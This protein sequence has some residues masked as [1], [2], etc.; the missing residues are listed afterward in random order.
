MLLAAAVHALAAD[1]GV[2]G[3][4]VAALPLTS[5]A[6]Q[7]SLLTTLHDHALSA[8][9]SC[10][11][12]ELG[13]G[14]RAQLLAAYGTLQWA[15]VQ[16]AARTVVEHHVRDAA[17]HG[18]PHLTIRDRASAMAATRREQLLDN[19]DAAVTESW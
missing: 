4:Q 19:L 12:D 14:E 16:T 7:T 18:C 15:A 13:S 8:L 1:A 9:Q 11:A 10:P 2:N 6:G 17:D 3:P 5:P